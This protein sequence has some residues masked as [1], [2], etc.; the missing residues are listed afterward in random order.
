MLGEA[1]GLGVGEI[2][3]E[4]GSRVSA[5]ELGKVEVVLG[6]W[7]SPAKGSRAVTRGPGGAGEMVGA[8]RGGH[9]CQEGGGRMFCVLCDAVFKTFHVALLIIAQY[10]SD[11][12][13]FTSKSS[14]LGKDGHPAGG[15]WLALPSVRQ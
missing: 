4:A 7:R 11:G 2:F 6:T 5:G 12:S 14:T 10:R 9:G 3:E 13:T 8:S 15:V 1:S